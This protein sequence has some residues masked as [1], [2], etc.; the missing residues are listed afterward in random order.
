[1]E[2]GSTKSFSPHSESSLVHFSVD[3]PIVSVLVFLAPQQNETLSGSG[4]DTWPQEKKEQLPL[5]KTGWKKVFSSWFCWQCLLQSFT[6]RE[7]F[8][9]QQCLGDKAEKDSSYY[10]DF[11]FQ[12][13]TSLQFTLLFSFQSPQERFIYSFISH[14][15]FL[16]Q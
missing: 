6:F 11:F 9:F 5:K 12:I 8:F 10:I 7:C 3:S 4:I 1:M 13:L 16:H 2:V 14:P 15:E